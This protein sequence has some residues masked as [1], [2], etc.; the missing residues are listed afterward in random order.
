MY[1]KNPTQNLR[2][3]D[4][5]RET[6]EPESSRKTQKLLQEGEEAVIFS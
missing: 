6:A 2:N 3:S 5:G 4:L 1:Y